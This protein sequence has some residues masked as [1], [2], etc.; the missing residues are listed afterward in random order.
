MS[1]IEFF[2]RSRYLGIEMASLSY[3]SQRIALEHRSR[4]RCRRRDCNL[5]EALC[6][7]SCSR[8]P[9]RVLARVGI[10]L[11]GDIFAPLQELWNVGFRGSAN[12]AGI[13]GFGATP[14]VWMEGSGR[15][16]TAG[17]PMFKA[18]KRTF[19]SDSRSAANYTFAVFANGGTSRSSIPTLRPRKRPRPSALPPRSVL[20]QGIRR[21]R[22]RTPQG[23]S[24]PIAS[25]TIAEP[26]RP[27]V[28]ECALPSPLAYAR[29][30]AQ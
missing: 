9:L 20:F 26:A 1:R 25:L 15:E 18:G 21:S 19:V 8:R 11:T 13:A 30:D 10:S 22:A 27:L 17:I 23:R 3:T 16:P 12:R 24:R 4:R 2:S 6:R 7:L 14:T 5:P 29:P 28:R